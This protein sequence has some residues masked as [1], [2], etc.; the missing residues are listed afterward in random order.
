MMK[1]AALKRSAGIAMSIDMDHSDRLVSANGSKKRQADRMITAN[2]KRDDTGRD[3]APDEILDI[4]VR[5]RKVE[6]AAEG[7][8][9]HIRH[10][11]MSRRYSS[12]DMLVRA[13][14]IDIANGAGTKARTGAVCHSEIHRYPEERYVNISEVGGS[15]RIVRRFQQGWNAAIRCLAIIPVTKYKLTDFAELRIENISAGGIAIAGPQLVQTQN[16]RHFYRPLLP[17]I[18]NTDL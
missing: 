6:P 5:L 11:D 18:L 15:I 16:I 4:L 12:K 8:I 2:G 13:D 17:L 3:D 7:Y 10:P 9:A 14:T 1:F